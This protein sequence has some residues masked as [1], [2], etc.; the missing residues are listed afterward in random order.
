[1]RFGNKHSSGDVVLVKV[2]FVDDFEIKRR[3]AL[4]LFEEFGNIVVTG[5]TS[6]TN[7]RGVPL[8]KKDGAVKE[9][10][11]KLNYVFTIST[12]MVEKFLFSLSSAKKTRVFDALVGKLSGLKT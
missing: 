12:S 2:P 4:I 7:M 3:P 6:N 11:I 10:I 8:T 9:S 5:I 1:M